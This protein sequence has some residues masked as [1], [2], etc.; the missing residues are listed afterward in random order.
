MQLEEKVVSSPLPKEPT[1]PQSV[2]LLALLRHKCNR[3]TQHQLLQL[4]RRTAL[5]PR[6]HQLEQAKSRAYNK[7]LDSTRTMTMT[8]T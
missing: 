4:S 3:L 2:T 8:N 1:L 6:Y 7:W 5:D